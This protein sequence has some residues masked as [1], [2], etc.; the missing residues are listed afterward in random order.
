MDGEYSER[1]IKGIFDS[2]E[3]A[4]E[5]VKLHNL[6]STFRDARV[7]PYELNS[8]PKPKYEWLRCFYNVTENTIASE[9]DWSEENDY[10][11]KM[12]K[13]QFFEFSIRF[14]ERLADESVLLKIA[15]DRWARYKYE[16]SD[17]E[18]TNV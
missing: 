2:E 12:G 15:Q 5:Y 16:H 18:E 7:I 1:E 8:V 3:K 10:A 14:Q 11:Y 17:E 4:N 13:A 9:E 6:G